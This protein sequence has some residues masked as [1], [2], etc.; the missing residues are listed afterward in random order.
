M[1]LP[2]R[3]APRW[4]R[5]LRRKIELLAKRRAP[6]MFAEKSPKVASHRGFFCSAKGHAWLERD[7][8]QCANPESAF[9]AL[10]KKIEA[11]SADGDAFDPERS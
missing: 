10:R 7:R 4:Q 11:L 9:R 5:Y 3:V 6:L 2:T 1:S 8:C